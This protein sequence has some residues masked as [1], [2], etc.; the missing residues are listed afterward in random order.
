MKIAAASMQL[1]S[2]HFAS[3]RHEVTETLRM[4]VGRPEP[5]AVAPE[6]ARVRI[7]D[8]AQA[9]L[10]AESAAAEKVG[11]TGSQDRDPRL[12]LI[13]A[14][15][16][17]ML[18]RRIR[19]FDSSQIEAGAKI[20]PTAELD[21]GDTN[22]GAGFGVEYDYREV[23]SESEETRFSAAGKVLTADGREIA[24]NLS[25]EM[26][27]SYYQ[28]S[29]VSLRLGDAIR[30][31]DPLILNFAGNAAQLSDSRIEFDIDADGH[32]DEI[33]FVGSGSAFLVFD[34]NRDGEANDG[35]ELFGPASGN[36]FA[37]LAA[38]DDDG[39][40]WIDESDAAWTDLALWDSDETGMS[41]LRSLAE[42][43][44]GALS[45]SHVTTPFSIKD[46]TNGTRALIRSSGIFLQEDGD[47]GTIQQLDLT[48]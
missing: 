15:L 21:A 24:F 14:M 26:Q 38:L 3:Q 42:A 12:A 5:R 25:L 9:A 44:V 36:G 16:E 22:S 30:P 23:L 17:H 37:E 10:E 47:A 29:S 7:S 13:K 33:N 28:E 19:V 27:R 34:R 32:A 4:W 43:G 11:E 20:N 8:A 46:E 18:G 41:R 48:A 35:S 40:G 31:K 6:N 45:L 2:S 39:N 1:G